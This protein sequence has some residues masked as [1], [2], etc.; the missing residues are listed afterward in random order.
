MWHYGRFGEWQDFRAFPSLPFPI[1][2]LGSATLWRYGSA[3]FDTQILF[4]VGTGDLLPIVSRWA[5]V[6]IR[7]IGEPEG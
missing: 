5:A 1:Y 3:T 6:T 7:V 2:P 4:L